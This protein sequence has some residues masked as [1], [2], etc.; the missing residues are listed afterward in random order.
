MYSEKSVS[1]IQR[2]VNRGLGW[3]RMIFVLG[4]AVIEKGSNCGR[5]IKVRTTSGIYVVSDGA[6]NIYTMMEDV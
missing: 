4:G 2:I 3:N 6:Y 1:S 5:F